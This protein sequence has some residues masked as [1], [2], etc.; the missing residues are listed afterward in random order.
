M[1]VYDD[2]LYCNA[3]Y[4]SMLHHPYCLLCPHPPILYLSPLLLPSPLTMSRPLS[5][6]FGLGLSS[7]SAVQLASYFDL[8][9]FVLS[10]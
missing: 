1:G 7:L 2:I 8:N 6:Y 3:V 5:V 4:N 10:C 9:F